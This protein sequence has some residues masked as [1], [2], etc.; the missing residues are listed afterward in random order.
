MTSAQVTTAAMTPL[1]N[2]WSANLSKDSMSAPVPE[3][4]SHKNQAKTKLHSLDSPE[5][6]SSGASKIM[7]DV[8]QMS[9]KSNAAHAVEI[10]AMVP[11]I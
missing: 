1:S 3:S 5:L 11:K 6:R 2:D 10:G 4:G 9:T 8:C 7:P